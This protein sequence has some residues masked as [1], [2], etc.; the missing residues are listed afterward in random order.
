MSTPV[1]VDS[2]D[3]KTLLFATA[4]IK[5]VENAL[6][7]AK[8]D[9][10]LMDL[11]PPLTEAHD[12]LAKAWR[13]AERKATMPE[14]FSPATEQEIKQLQAWWPKHED[15]SEELFRFQP[16]RAGE[17]PQPSHAA[18]AAEAT[19]GAGIYHGEAKAAWRET[20][21]L[22]ARGLIELGQRVDIMLWSE[23][24]ERHQRTA[25][26]IWMRITQRGIDAIRAA[27]AP[28]NTQENP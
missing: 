23:S 1:T 22:A 6:K 14:R 4:A 27:E 5:G 20:R 24:G 12:R 17:L 9:P 18:L 21:S 11:T 13:G 19:S 28:P 25:P 2:D 3:L 10:F 16:R 15:D 7:Q 8:D 26:E